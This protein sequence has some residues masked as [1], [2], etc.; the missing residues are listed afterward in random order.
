MTVTVLA[1]PVRAEDTPP[2]SPDTQIEIAPQ[3]PEGKVHAEAPSPDEPPPMRPRRAG[4]VLESSLGALG[5]V[6]QFRHV[7]PTASW[8]HGQLGYEV[9][10]WLML[11]GEGELAYTDTSESVD[12]SH[13]AAF[14]IWGVGG[15]GRATFHATERVAMFVQGDVDALVADVPHGTLAIY[16]FRSAESLQPAFGPRLGL[17][18]Y[19]MDRHLA[20]SLQ[21]G[22]RYANGFAKFLAS[23]DIPV[24]WDAAACLRYTF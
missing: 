6:G 23:S 7:A 15:G 8:F 10:R 9:T 16:G 14:P 20:L 17:E 24:L 1:A 3:P 11:F 18:W 5:F 22:A 2:L 13:V 21:G 4:L 19:Q 12:E